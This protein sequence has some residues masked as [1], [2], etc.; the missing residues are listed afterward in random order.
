MIKEKNFVKYDSVS[1]AQF[2]NMGN[3]GKLNSFAIR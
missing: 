3:D 2:Q 1:S